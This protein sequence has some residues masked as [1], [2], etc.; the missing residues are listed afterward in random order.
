MKL[1]LV[2]AALLI[3]AFS[4][5]ASEGTPVLVPHAQQ[6]DLVAEATGRTYRISIAVPEKMDSA[7]KYP[8]FYVLDGNWYFAPT[9]VNLAESS[10]ARKLSP[11]IVV[12]IC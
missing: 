7:K 4:L 5:A 12:G 6:F 2:A 9:A 10:G 8:V 1:P 3:A 11:A